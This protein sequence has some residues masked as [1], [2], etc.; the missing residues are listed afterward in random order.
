MQI[1]RLPKRHYQTAVQA[2]KQTGSTVDSHLLSLAA[3]RNCN[4]DPDQPTTVVIE[5]ENG[6][7]VATFNVN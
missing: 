2:S 4:A 6:E 5:D 1:L 7:T 3:R